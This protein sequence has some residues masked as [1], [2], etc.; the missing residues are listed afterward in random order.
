MLI[1]T[2]CHL[3]AAEFD[4]DRDAV[5]ERA[6]AEG[7]GV[8][9]VP[10]ISAANFAPVLAACRRYPGCL[11]ALGLH[12]MYIGEHR[13]EHLDALRRAVEAEKPVAVGEIGLDFYVPDLDPAT[14]EFYFIEQLKIARDYDLPVLLHARRAVDA[15]LKGLRRVRVKGGIAHAFS[16][17]RHQAEEFIKLGFKLGFGG[18]FTYS[19]ANRLK[20]LAAELPLESIVLETDAPDIPPAFLDAGARNS[21]EYLPR[22]AAELAATRGAGMDEVASATTR[23]AMELFGLEVA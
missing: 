19:R 8:M 15:V 21:P 20:T 4:G 9:V 7:V 17:S 18:A 5:Y 2:H 6:R 14:Q 23:N 10:A 16:G 11:P 1:D 13:P 3:D 22:I 12:P